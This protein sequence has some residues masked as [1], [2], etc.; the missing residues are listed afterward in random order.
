[1]YGQTPEFSHSIT[2]PSPAGPIVRLFTAPPPFLPELTFFLFS[3][4]YE[5]KSRHGL[6]T[7]AELSTAPNQAD[8]WRSAEAVSKVLE[9]DR[10]GSLE[11]SRR[12]VGEIVGLKGGRARVLIKAL[13]KEM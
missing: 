2:I 1:M 10:Y 12:V 8:W 11:E 7:S 3:Q 5:V 13:Q 9:G 4:T 6:I